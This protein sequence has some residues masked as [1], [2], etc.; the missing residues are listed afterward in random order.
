MTIYRLLLIVDLLAGAVLLLFF[1]WGMSDGTV[2]YAPGTWLAALA[3]V[4]VTIGGAVALRRKG[5]VGLAMLLLLP[6]A[7]PALLYGMFLL[8]VLILHPR[9]N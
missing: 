1:L 8:F 5:N 6:V 9:W 2:A 4:G 3:G 7:V